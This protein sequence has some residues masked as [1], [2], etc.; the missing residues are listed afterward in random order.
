MNGCTISFLFFIFIFLF[1]LCF[2]LMVG[3]AWKRRGG[4]G[5]FSGLSFSALVYICGNF[6]FF[7]FSHPGAATYLRSDDGNILG[8]HTLF[9]TQ[10]HTSKVNYLRANKHP[11]RASQIR[12]LPFAAVLVV[13]RLRQSRMNSAKRAR[14]S[15][16]PFSGIEVSTLAWWFRAV[17]VSG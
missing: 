4:K 11:V 3:V 10:V 12:L 14:N 7:F 8:G 16:P 5:G 15:W 1:S 9:A 6:V 17:M 2:D 13:G